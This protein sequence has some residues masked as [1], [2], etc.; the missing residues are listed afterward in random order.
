MT[1]KRCV[2]TLGGDQFGDLA[3]GTVSH[4][5]NFVVV[6]ADGAEHC[7]QKPGNPGMSVWNKHFRER[8]GLIINGIPPSSADST[9]TSL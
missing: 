1:A 7:P 9:I 2:P 3:P 8:K 4:Q 6:R 5:P